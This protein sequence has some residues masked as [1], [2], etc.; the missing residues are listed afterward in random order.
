[1]ESQK[2]YHLNDVLTILISL[3]I[4]VIIF[5]FLL[6]TGI[7]NPFLNDILTEISLTFKNHVHQEIIFIRGL[8]V[9]VLIL[10]VLL[11]ERIDISSKLSL[12]KKRVFQF[13]FVIITPLFIYGY[14]GFYYYDIYL[15]PSIF[16]SHIF[17]TTIAISPFK[18]EFKNEDIFGVSNLK[19]KYQFVFK[20]KNNK[21]LT[22]HNIFSHFW[23]EGGTGSGKSD[24]FL[25]FMIKQSYDMNLAGVIY[26]LEGN[27]RHA[28]SPILG[29]IAYKYYK[30]NNNKT[31]KNNHSFFHKLF[32]KKK[33]KPVKFAFLNF[34]DPTRSVRINPLAPRYVEKDSDVAA[35]INGFMET[36]LNKSN[37]KGGQNDFW[38]KYGVSYVRSIA[39][40]L[41]YSYPQYL[42]LPHIICL[43]TY[44]DDKK[45]FTWL[46]HDRR[47][48][49]DM[50][51]L[52]S[53][54]KGGANSTLASA[55]VSGQVPLSDM[56]TAE[57]F[58]VLSKDDFDLNVTNPE[59]PYILV[60]GN[61]PDM[62]RRK[63]FA[64]AIS[65]IFKTIMTKMH[66]SKNH[67]GIFHFDEFPS[68]K[69]LNIDQFMSEIRK[70]KICVILGLQGYEQA[71]DNYGDETAKNMK[72]NSNN[73]AIGR[74][75][76]EATIKFVMDMLGDKE[77]K[78]TSHTTSVDSKSINESVKREKVLQPRLISAQA[79]GHF[80]G[81]VAD[82]K[83]P[84]FFTQFK[85]ANFEGEAIPQFS[86][87]IT[88][89][90]E[91]MNY[92]IMNN[93]AEHNKKRILDEAYSIIEDF[94]N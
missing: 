36:L 79:T 42:T 32:F 82:G 4:M 6:Y 47:V 3:F 72:T 74:T 91:D 10:G 5:D 65:V 64:P 34:G 75:G 39:L 68:V 44:P 62:Y 56:S 70:K 19:N 28:D 59:N 20:L 78:S 49:Q 63:L 92:K 88:T 8:Y 22:F 58:W 86:N 23:I 77:M 13:L 80:L 69:V 26:D 12:S 27:P 67:P 76:S 21:T 29:R 60:V 73:R 2:K 46:E 57:A 18:N 9:F 94:F 14:T 16:V 35:V 11:I 52:L 25:K 53:A 85:R 17:I 38:D 54:Y 61:D 71:K 50:A 93:L 90:D 48:H 41:Y 51:S 30:N 1:M 83:P 43:A 40:R 45:M 66:R 87:Y 37:K 31:V 55:K 15:Y 7:I 24:T 89:K 33:E 81:W 84:Y